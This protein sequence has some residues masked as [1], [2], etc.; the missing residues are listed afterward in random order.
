M[1]VGSSQSRHTALSEINV[2]PLVD[3]MLVLLIIFMVTAPMMQ[4]GLDVDLPETAASGVET[5]NEPFV[6][7]IDKNEKIVISGSKDKNRVEISL[8]NLKTKLAAIFGTRK[9]KQ[10]YIQA[11]KTVSYGFV[12]AT[13]AEIRAAGILNIGLVTLPKASP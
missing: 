7:V 5:T 1:Q 3:V 8:K 9:N 4:Q 2:T 6:L 12:A 11:D 13:M 10:V